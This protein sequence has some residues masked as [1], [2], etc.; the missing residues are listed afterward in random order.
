MKAGEWAARLL[1]VYD[2]D[3]S[4]LLEM[5]EFSVIYDCVPGR[6]SAVAEVLLEKPNANAN[7]NAN[8]NDNTNANANANPNSNTSAN[9]NTNER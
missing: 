8:A 5:G 6:Q 1:S 3:G 7:A 4:G 2:A 9:P